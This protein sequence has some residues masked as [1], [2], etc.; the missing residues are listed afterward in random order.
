[1][2]NVGL[3]N[4]EIAWVAGSE[5]KRMALRSPTRAFPLVSPGHPAA[6]AGEN[7]M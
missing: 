1:M 2:M 3:I 5:A 6:L 7:T 4:A